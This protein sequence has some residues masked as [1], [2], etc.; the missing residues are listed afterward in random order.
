MRKLI[1]LTVCFLAFSLVGC[2]EISENALSPL[3]GLEW[4]GNYDEIKNQL[5]D[6]GKKLVAER[7]KNEQKIK[8]NMQDYENI[9]LFETDC[10]LTLC[11]T[12]NGLVGFNY[13]DIDKNK[14]YKDWFSVLESEYGYP[15][16]ESSGMASWY[17][18]PL[19]KDT[20]VYLFNLEEGV[21]VSFYASADSPD[22]SYSGNIPAPE[23]RTPIV[24]VTPSDYSQNY[25]S[26]TVSSN[27]V[28]EQTNT[29]VSTN[30]F[31]VVTDENGTVIYSSDNPNNDDNPNNNANN[32]VQ[33][34][35][36]GS[37]STATAVT[38]NSSTVSTA[39]TA[40]V[41][42]VVTEIQTVEEDN[43]EDYLINGLE[44]YGSPDSERA[45][46]SRY[47]QLYEYR[48][49]ES[50]QPWELIMEYENVRYLGKNCDSV[51]CFTSLGLVGINY[52]DA[53]VNNYD[54]WINKLSEMYGSP[55]ETQ[56]DYSVWSGNPVGEGTMIYVFVLEDG[57]QISFF[58]D[59]TGSELA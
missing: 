51:L 26:T 13:H 53:N 5:T 29:T 7:E 28:S 58:A 9:P 48:T 36:F 52:F 30:N 10:D 55:N 39:L 33:G 45:K 19:G 4:F 35:I 47:S 2:S 50:G 15:T 32:E 18:N 56:Y 41:T 1:Y 46:M 20:A 49:E 40:S 3:M 54:F 22:K 21:Q 14:N 6:K 11:F 24:P 59:D 38:N 12:E 16:E 43:S 42:T 25:S 57:V 27:Q 31:S 23:I 34:S 8:Q 17:E 44:F 37:T